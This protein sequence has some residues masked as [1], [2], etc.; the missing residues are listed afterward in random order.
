MHHG[1]V[2]LESASKRISTIS[3]AAGNPSHVFC[4]AICLRA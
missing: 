4:T 3:K 2:S 1:A